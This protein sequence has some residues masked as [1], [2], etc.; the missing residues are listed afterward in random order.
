M[1]EEHEIL[2]KAMQPYEHLLPPPLNDEDSICI[3]AAHL[4]RLLAKELGSEGIQR[5]ES[6][7]PDEEPA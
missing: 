6:R 4:I 2:R 7:R 3:A 5:L 1:D